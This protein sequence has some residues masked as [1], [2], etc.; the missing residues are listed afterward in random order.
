M[1]LTYSNSSVV[2]SNRFDKC[3]P[4]KA[5]VESLLYRT[6]GMFIHCT[7]LI[8]SGP[9]YAR[10]VRNGFDFISKRPFVSKEC[11]VLIDYDQAVGEVLKEE[12]EIHRLRDPEQAANV[13]LLIGPKHGNVLNA[14]HRR[15]EDLDLMDTWYGCQTARPGDVPAGEIFCR[16]LK[17]QLDKWPNRGKNGKYK[18]IIFTVVLRNSSGGK[19]KLISGINELLSIID[20][21]IEGFDF[22][23]RYGNSPW[24]VS[25][26][27]HPILSIHEQ[28]VLYKHSGR[29]IKMRVFTYR[30]GTPMLTGVIVWR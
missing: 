26:P 4:A 17:G 23:K 11:V 29:I 7:P 24:D 30:D 12:R 14:K 25:Y 1:A 15:F 10:H 21:E 19:G 3:A 6:A 13:K 28:I 5:F 18:C 16:R 20:A 8:V 22:T 27:M 2:D 9:A